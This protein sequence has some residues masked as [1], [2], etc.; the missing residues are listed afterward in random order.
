LDKKTNTAESWQ[1]WKREFEF[2]MVATETDKKDIKIKTS[3]LVTC[4]GQRS[5]EV[6]YNF[7]FD[8]DEDSMK[9][10]IV[11]DKFDAHDSNSSMLSN[12]IINQLMIL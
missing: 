6:Y 11:I 1:R 8:D 3:T 2:F 5:R 12:T 10:K 9:Y 4:I 7:V